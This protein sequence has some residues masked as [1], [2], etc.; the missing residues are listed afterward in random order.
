[1]HSNIEVSVGMVEFSGSHRRE[2]SGS[3]GTGSMLL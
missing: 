3:C 1:L 2:S